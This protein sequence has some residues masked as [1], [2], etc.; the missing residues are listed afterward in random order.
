ML[1]HESN[2]NVSGTQYK[3]KKSN[4]QKVLNY[5]NN[6]FEQEFLILQ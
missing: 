3:Y 2:Q 4:D 1:K 6:S 5:D